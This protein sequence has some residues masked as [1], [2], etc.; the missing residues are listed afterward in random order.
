Q[1][2]ALDK[3]FLEVEPEGFRIVRVSLLDPF[4]NKTTI[5]FSEI[6]EGKVLSPSLFRFEIPPGVEVV[7]PPRLPPS[8]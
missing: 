3:L 4:N 7:R 6:E 2:S 5:T 1:D 8:R